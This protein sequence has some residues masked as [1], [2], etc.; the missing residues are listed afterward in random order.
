MNTDVLVTIGAGGIGQA[1]ARRQGPGRTV[2]LADHNESA[3]QSAAKALKDAGHTVATQSVDISSRESVHALAQ[4]AAGLGSVQQVVNTAGL[5]P[6]QAPAEAILA[7][8]L[9]GVA[10][11]LEE[12][13]KV[14][15]PGGAGLTVSS[16]AGHM[17]GL[18]PLTSEQERDL[19]LT[20]TDALLDLPFVAA[21]K[22]SGPAYAL[23]KRANHLR[24][25]AAAVTWGQRGAR[26]NSVSPGII[27]TPL[28]RDE[29]S[30]PGAAGYQKMIEASAAGR[31][32]TADEVAAVAA[33]LLGPD[34]AF[35]TGSDLLMDGGVIATLATG[36][37]TVGGN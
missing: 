10:L 29:M 34:A 18:A 33:F 4:T 25:Q 1:I 7:V 17:S 27:L 21:V 35:I 32:G 31:V 3:L 23:A 16:M 15:A 8:D 13:A 5:S 2:L 30:G 12:F 36:H 14:I 6:I 24:V 20:P 11:V 19:A 26:V 9:A 28:A 22:D 37:L